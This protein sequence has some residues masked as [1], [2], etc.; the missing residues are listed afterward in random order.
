MKQLRFNE[1]GQMIAYVQKGDL[2][3]LLRMKEFV[4][5]ELYD[6]ARTL[7]AKGP[8]VKGL[9]KLQDQLNVEDINS[10]KFIV[11]YD[12]AKDLSTEKLEQLKRYASEN[13]KELSNTLRLAY[14]PGIYFSNH[15]QK[16]L[17]N[18]PGISLPLIDSNRNNSD[19]MVD[20]RIACAQTQVLCYMHNLRDLINLK[21]KNGIRNKE[22]HLSKRHLD[23]RDSR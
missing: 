9:Y 19:I 21:Q 1:N 17:D 11:D 18:Y 12:Q 15:E 7:L 10:Y 20:D 16:F 13:F 8:T 14:I 22:A 23:D 2:D 4:S 6:E 5:P 3:S